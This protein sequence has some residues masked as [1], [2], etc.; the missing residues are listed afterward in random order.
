MCRLWTHVYELLEQH[1]EAE[2][3][4]AAAEKKAKEAAP[5]VVKSRVE[6][7][8]TAVADHPRR[9]SQPGGS[10]RLLKSAM[11]DAV[12]STSPRA[13]RKRE[14]ADEPPLLSMRTAGSDDDGGLHLP[15]RRATETD[16]GGAAPADLTALDRNVD[17]RAL[18]GKRPTS[19][20][21]DG[22]LAT[23]RTARASDLVSSSLAA[24]ASSKGTWARP[25]LLATSTGR[26]LPRNLARA[27][28]AAP[29][30]RAA[31]D[32]DLAEDEEAILDDEGAADADDA[33]A[34]AEDEAAAGAAPASAE[35]GTGRV[36]CK[37]FP[38]CLNPSC[39]FYHDPALLKRMPALIGHRRG[40]AGTACSHAFS[41]HVMRFRSS[42]RPAKL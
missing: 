6:R 4:K 2:K 22:G 32:A 40:L 10:D 37:Y 42:Q 33:A 15:R 21:A 16:A 9:R 19:G 25:S 31:A 7:P 8:E 35:D 12:Q 30:R 27:A 29:T 24:A 3:K 1:E 38:K 28:A 18:L 11:T 36:R 26:A 20:R 13:D 41:V 23:K 5:V 34:A 39:T 14:R 17:L